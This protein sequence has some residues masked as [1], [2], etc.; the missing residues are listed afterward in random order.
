MDIGKEIIHLSRLVVSKNYEDASRVA[1]RAMKRLASD[2]PDLAGEVNTVLRAMESSSVT[3]ANQLIEQP[4]PVDIDSRLDLLRREINPIVDSSYVWPEPIQSELLLTLK[5]RS[6][7]EELIDANLQPTK[8]LLFVGPPGVGK[9]VAARW[10]ASQLGRPLLTLDLSAVMSSYLGR[11][12]GNIRTVL[13]YAK[14]YPCVLLLDEFDAIAKRRDDSG[15]IGELK[16]LVTVILQE[17]DNWPSYGVLVAATN[18]PELLDPAVWRRFDRVLKFPNP[19]I[20]EV[21]KL[22][23]NLLGQDFIKANSD[24]VEILA[25]IYLGNSFSE[26]TRLINLARKSAVV[27]ELDIKSALEDMIQHDMDDL[28]KAT[29]ITYAIKLVGSGISQRHAERITGISR[30][31]IAKNLKIKT[32]D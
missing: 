7:A 20:V 26:I 23:E 14:K 4:L 6:K 11:T 12:G 29:K 17:V 22:I 9:T 30:L 10:L 3:R 28:D 8:S 16:R 21:K 18:H 25:C 32:K 19:T 31:T 13:D 15:E 27:S 1:K 5:E 2:R 24:F